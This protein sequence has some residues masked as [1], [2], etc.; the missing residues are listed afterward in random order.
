MKYK[1]ISILLNIM[2]LHRWEDFTFI[3]HRRPSCCIFQPILPSERWSQ[4][5]REKLANNW[6]SQKNTSWYT[7][8]NWRR[9]WSGMA[10]GKLWPLPCY[11]GQSHLQLM[12]ATV[13]ANSSI[14]YHLT[15]FSLLQRCLQTWIS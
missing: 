12:K 4:N 8:S 1:L 14:F 9:A 10:S 7:F 2:F 13:L 5:I 6:E 15:R 11:F 3:F